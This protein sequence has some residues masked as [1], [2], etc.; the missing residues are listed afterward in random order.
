MLFDTQSHNRESKIYNS[1]VYVLQTII[2]TLSKPAFIL[3]ELNH[4][5]WWE[6][7]GL[8]G[9]VHTDNMHTHAHAH[10]LV[11]E[12]RNVLRVGLISDL[13]KEGLHFSH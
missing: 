12:A 4:L 8:S 10:N 6:R 9:T 1:R 2:N 7:S 13:V 3:T 11:R 5:K